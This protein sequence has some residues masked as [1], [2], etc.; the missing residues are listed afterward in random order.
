MERKSCHISQDEYPWPTG[1]QS[2]ARATSPDAWSRPSVAAAKTMASR[3]CS[4]ARWRSPG[5][6]HPLGSIVCDGSPVSLDIDGSAGWR[7]FP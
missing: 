3:Q 6:W 1:Q 2:A 4:M 7:A 5:V